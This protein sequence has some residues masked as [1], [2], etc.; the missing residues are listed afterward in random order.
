M[1][2]GLAGKMRPGHG[3]SHILAG[4]G[5]STTVCADIL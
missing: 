3:L 2:A 4:A 1:A 5:S